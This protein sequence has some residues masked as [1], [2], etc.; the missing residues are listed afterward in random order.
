VWQRQRSESRGRT[1]LITDDNVR[2]ES[3]NHGKGSVDHAQ[4]GEQGVTTAEDMAG[5]PGMKES[6]RVRT[7]AIMTCAHA[8]DKAAVYNNVPVA[9][10]TDV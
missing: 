10:N 7:N 5:H 2:L 6:E 9:V 3:Q 8:C 4:V 1:H